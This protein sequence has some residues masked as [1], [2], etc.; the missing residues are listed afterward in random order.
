MQY[1]DGSTVERVNHHTIKSR[2]NYTT[3]SGVYYGAQYRYLA[4]NEKFP[5]YHNLNL[6][7]A[8]EM[9]KG[10][11]MSIMALNLLSPNHAEG[12]P[13]S[14]RLNSVI[15]QGVRAKIVYQF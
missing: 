9:F 3:N 13:D 5:E 12:N 8:Y 7:V 1:E 14:K 2:Y 10:M 4:K 6:R 15:E 11:E